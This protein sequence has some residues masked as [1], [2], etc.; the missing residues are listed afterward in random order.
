MTHDQALASVEAAGGIA[1]K[2]ISTKTDL[3]V[4][5]EGSGRKK[6]EMANERGTTVIDANS[7]L[8]VIVGQEEM[9]PR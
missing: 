6:V 2:T 7:F 1:Q 4:L 8:R 5:G 3:L 9:P